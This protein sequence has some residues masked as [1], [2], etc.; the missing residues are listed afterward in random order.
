MGDETDLVAAVERSTD[1]EVR[2]TFDRRVRD[3][4]ER[5]R[6]DIRSGRLDTDEFAVGMELEAYA[7]DT[8]GRLARIPERV[9]ER[10]GCAKELGVH[11]LEVNSTA[12]VFDAA[13]VAEQ[14]DRIDANVSAAIDALAAED[15]APALDA[16]WTIPPVGGTDAY[17]GGIEKRDGVTVAENMRHHPR[18][19]A[20][21]NEILERSGGR[22]TLDVPGATLSYPTILA[23]SL[24]TSIQPHLQ[25]PDVDAFPAYFNAALRTAGPIL[26]LTSN[27]PFLPA[28]CYDDDPDVIPATPHELRI[29]VFEKSINAGAPRGE[30]KVRFPSDLDRATDVVDRVVE[31][32][33]YAPVLADGPGDPDDYRST[34]REYD[35]KRGVHWR[36]VRGV[37][38]GQPVGTEHAGASLRIEY[39]PLPTQPTVCDTVSV[40]VLV[41]G[42]LRGL[43]DADHPLTDLPWTAAR[44][45]FY[46]AVD[47][48][49]DADLAWVTAD[50]ERT[51]DPETIYDE[52]FAFAR[53]G[54]RDAGIADDVIDSYLD[55]VERRRDGAAP[56]AWKKARVRDAV[57]DGATLP[58]AIETMQRDY[59]DRAGGET[60]FADW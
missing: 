21:D 18:Y 55:P 14:A 46:D 22:I 11:N 7:V 4:A 15:L 10:G 43:I 30:G 5:I 35:H 44:D 58:E 6:D 16:M 53:R 34:I 17:L 31:D 3:Q 39:R 60:V 40:Q 36:W 52:V 42:L 50:G 45:C 32:E 54:L 51:A 24:A 9:F 26:A 38:G 37:I 57:D 33:T 12:T 56:S 8:D 13:G 28:D 41:V 47:R 48:G 27:S 1:P 23:E 19:V 25:I 2:E 59:L 49:P 29:H 20:L